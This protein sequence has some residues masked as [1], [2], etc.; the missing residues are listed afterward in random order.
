MMKKQ[1]AEFQKIKEGE[2]K[3]TSPT[4]YCHRMTIK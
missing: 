4:T 1:E 2:K 3:Q